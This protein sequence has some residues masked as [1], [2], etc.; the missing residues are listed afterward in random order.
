MEILAVALDELALACRMTGHSLDDLWVRYLATGGNRSRRDLSERLA[1]A[2]WPDP[3]ERV[4]Q[5]AVDDALRDLGLP[6]LTAPRPLASLVDVPCVLGPPT[7]DDDLLR[8]PGEAP[9]SG[10]AP[11]F[12]PRFTELLARSARAR[13]AARDTRAWARSVRRDDGSPGRRRPGGA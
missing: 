8:L 12:G 2:V 10:P 13:A 11:A 6:P 1:G 7:V 9:S 5:V 3:E 4:L